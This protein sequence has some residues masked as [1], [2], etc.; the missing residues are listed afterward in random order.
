MLAFAGG[1]TLATGPAA[2]YL[3]AHHALIPM[4]QC[5]RWTG[6]NYTA[7]N[8]VAYGSVWVGASAGGL[9]LAGWNYLLA[10]IVGSVPA[11]LPLAAIAAGLWF[12]RNSPDLAETKDLPP[13]AAMAAALALSAWPRWTADAMIHT[14]ALSW[15]LCAILLYRLAGPRLRF[16]CCGV[17]LLAAALSM[18]AKSLA[19]FNYPPR[20]TRVGT[21]R[22]PDEEGEFLGRLENWIHPGDSLFSFP[23]FP[24]AY[25]F[26]NA[27]ILRV[28]PLCSRE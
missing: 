27:Q 4:I 12:W 10:S 20:E 24:S 22:D 17:A 26:L 23:Y 15:S 19:P 18:G 13:L 8:T 11:V 2:I 25:F 6:A 21:L 3:A 16:W 1:G 14:A 9:H 28:I 7:A 5:L